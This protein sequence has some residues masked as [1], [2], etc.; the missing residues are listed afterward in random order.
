MTH[1]VKVLLCKFTYNSCELSLKNIYLNSKFCHVCCVWIK[2][3]ASLH[4]MSKLKYDCFCFFI[5]A[6]S[7]VCGL[8]YSNTFHN[9]HREGHLN[10]IPNTSSSS[11]TVFRWVEIFNNL[12]NAEN[13]TSWRRPLAVWANGAYSQLQLPAA[14]TKVDERSSGMYRDSITHRT[15]HPE[16]PSS[17]VSVQKSKSTSV[18]T[19]RLFSRSGLF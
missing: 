6:N 9:N 17:H 13:R 18:I 12:G 1:N 2:M 8:V 16:K 3:N 15:E 4:H 7:S 10:P 11:T 19:T 14:L 5:S